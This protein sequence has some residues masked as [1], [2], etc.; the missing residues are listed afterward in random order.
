MAAT[1]RR[2]VIVVVL[3]IAVFGLAYPALVTLIGQTAFSAQADGSLVT[4]DGRTVG[5]KLVAQGFTGPRYFHERPSATT[6]AYNGM[7]TGGSNLGPN[8]K[9]LYQTVQQRIAAVLR[10]EGPYNPGLTARGIPVDAVTASFSGIDPQISVAYAHLQAPRV[11]AVRHLPL[12]T[13]NQLISQ[14]TAGRFLDVFGE[15]GVNVLQLNLALDR[16]AQ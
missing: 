4:R 16:T 5:S 1:L 3:S 11:A 15:A 14:N 13:V 7:A 9:S 10:L 2:S 6:P 12:R 8:S